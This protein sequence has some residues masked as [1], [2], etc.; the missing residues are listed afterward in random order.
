[1]VYSSSQSAKSD[2][3]SEFHS[4]GDVARMGSVDGRVCSVVFMT[5]QNLIA[6]D[7]DRH[8]RR[9]KMENCPNFEWVVYSCHLFFSERDILEVV[10]ESFATTNLSACLSNCPGIH[11]GSEKK[12]V[13]IYTTD[14]YVSRICLWG[15]RRFR[16]WLSNRDLARSQTAAQI[17]TVASLF[18]TPLLSTIHKT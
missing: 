1:M 17:H 14:C 4:D 9:S 3:S 5:G 10:V 6:E 11:N 15:G 2:L 13:K 18:I 12:S 8:G 16:S 7:L